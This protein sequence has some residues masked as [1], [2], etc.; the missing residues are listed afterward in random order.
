MHIQI[1]NFQLDGVTEDEY[2]GLCDQLAPAF[3]EVPGLLSKVWLSDPDNNSFGGVYTWRDRGAM[4]EF[5][6]SELFKNVVTHPNLTGITS[7]D[8]AVLEGPT[9]VT[10]GVAEAAA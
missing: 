1:V 2:R 6:A 4:D 10:R 9:S 3:A 7:K 5:A 8:F